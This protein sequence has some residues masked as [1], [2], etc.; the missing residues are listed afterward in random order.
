MTKA[1]EQIDKKK[2]R[3]NF[4][5]PKGAA[6]FPSLLEPDTAFDGNGEYHT[7]I[8]LDPSDPEVDKIVSKIHELTDEWYSAVY[9][10]LP[11]KDKGKA[12]KHV[13]IEDEYDENDE[14]TGNIIFKFRQKAVIK[15]KNGNEKNMMPPLFGL[16]KKT[17]EGG[18]VRGG[19]TIKVA[20]QTWPYYVN[21]TGMCG[22]KFRIRGIQIIENSG[23]TPD[24][25]GFDDETDGTEDYE[26]ETPDTPNEE[27]EDVDF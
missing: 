14:P 20:F 25:L 16:D 12:Y 22:L 27:D 21:A 10:A 5:T 8:V 6:R 23:V 17:W 13:S 2:Y 9:N 7:G 11:K 26:E 3:S 24:A 19:A 1:I 18:T 4:T 15:D